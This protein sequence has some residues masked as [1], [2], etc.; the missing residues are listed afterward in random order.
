MY[1]NGDGVEKDLK[2]SK[3]LWTEAAA[4]G[5]QSAIKGLNIL[6]EQFIKKNI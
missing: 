2:K 5:D 1:A 4:R 3:V 6:N